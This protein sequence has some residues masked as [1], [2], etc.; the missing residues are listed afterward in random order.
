M[1]YGS[2]DI[3]Q[4]RRALK[5]AA[6]TRCR[7][8]EFEARKVESMAEEWRPVPGYEERYSISSL[9]RIKNKK[10]LMMRFSIM[11]KG[12][13]LVSLY[14]TRAKSFKVSRL[15]ARAFHPNPNSLPEVNHKNGVKNDDRAGNLEWITSGDN[16]RHA[17]ATGLREYKK[18]SRS[19][20]LTQEQARAIRC[21]LRTESRQFLA[22]EFSVSVSTIRNIQIGRHWK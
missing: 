22:K 7:T 15:V 4:K 20:K 17:W 16:Q 21:R 3:Q 11:P 9:G 1:N 5:V 12:Y 2:Q 10:G 19:W 8:G 6:E 13:Q 18:P 14:D